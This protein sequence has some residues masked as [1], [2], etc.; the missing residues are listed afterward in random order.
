LAPL[1]AIPTLVMV[2]EQDVLTPPS[3]SEAIAS[4]LPDARLVVVHGSGH[5]LLLEAPEVVTEA[6]R[7]LIEQ[8]Q[9]A[10]LQ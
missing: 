6:L 1:R 8:V 3:H 2:G 4:A 7:S 9:G 5:M 10:V